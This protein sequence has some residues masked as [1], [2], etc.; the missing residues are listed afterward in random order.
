MPMSVMV[1]HWSMVDIRQQRIEKI[2][3]GGGRAR[4]RRAP[5]HPRRAPYG[6][7]GMDFSKPSFSSLEGA[8][9]HFP[10]KTFAIGGRRTI[11]KG[12]FGAKAPKG[13]MPQCPPPTAYAPDI[14]SK[15]DLAH[16]R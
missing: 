13:G 5:L 12:A 16:A 9:L 7:H 15:E 1:A 2:A 11:A 6:R 14:R 4:A 10:C 3:K 8:Q